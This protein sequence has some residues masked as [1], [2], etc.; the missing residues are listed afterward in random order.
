HALF[1]AAMRN[2]LRATP[3]AYAV[4]I[5]DGMVRTNPG[6]HAI[7]A[8]DLL[9]DRVFMLGPRRDV[10]RLTAAFDVACLTST[11]EGFPNV[12]GEA[13]ACGVECVVTDV[14]A[15]ST[16]V[17][18]TGIVVPSGS[19]DA[20]A[21]G[22]LLTLGRSPAERCALGKRARA[23]IVAQYSLEAVTAMYATLYRSV[24]RS[25]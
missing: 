7:L 5:G 23:R 1:I 16:I 6:L 12:I 24:S 4:L 9:R 3:T 10:A 22:V 15:A 19:A 8:D 17:G 14:G 18:D 25:A 21:N 20:F 11:S 2:V 13:M